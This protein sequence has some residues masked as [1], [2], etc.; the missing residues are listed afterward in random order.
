MLSVFL[1]H[2]YMHMY[3]G[4]VGRKNKLHLIIVLAFEKINQI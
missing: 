3:G 2:I 1:V 4:G